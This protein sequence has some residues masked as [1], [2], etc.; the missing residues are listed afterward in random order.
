M[1][2]LEKIPSEIMT[3]LYILLQNTPTLQT[4]QAVLHILSHSSHTFDKTPFKELLVNE[5]FNA[6]ADD[7]RVIGWSV[8]PDFVRVFG[9]GGGCIK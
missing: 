2:L 1:F 9:G 5:F 3:N 7:E 8:F 6:V 4:L